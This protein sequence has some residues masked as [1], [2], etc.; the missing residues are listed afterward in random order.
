MRPTIPASEELAAWVDVQ[1]TTLGDGWVE[2]LEPRKRE[3]AEF[4]DGYRADHRNEESRSSSNR[5]FYEAASV[6]VE[7]TDRWMTRWSGY[8]DAT[9]LDYACGDGT[10]TL[11]A[12]KTGARLAVGIDISETSVKN[13]RENAMR[14][15]VADRTRFLQRDCESTGFPEES[16][17][18]AL[19]SGMLHHLDLSRAYP[20][21]S[22]IMAPGG[23]ILCLEA[24]AYNPVI[25]LYRNRTPEL[26]TDWEKQHILG[27]R[28]VEM[29]K[30]WFRVENVRFFLMAA[31]LATLL[32]AG[33]IRRA[34]IR[35]GHGIDS[36]L[37]RVPGLQL[38]SWQFSFELVKPG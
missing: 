11:K 14:A 34:F 25:Q 12:A 15:G 24:L 19:C 37:T 3:E 6:V 35:V 36:V 27:M 9:F 5:R 32:P 13:A 31:P 7:H 2:N 20:E 17:T 22:R 38:W 23:R 29:A 30:R 26:R 4:H 33:P 1:P 16:F 28:E 18:A 10:Q 21:L 8:G